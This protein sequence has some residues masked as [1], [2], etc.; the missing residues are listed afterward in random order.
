MGGVGR[1]QMMSESGPMNSGIP[2]VDVWISCARMHT[3]EPLEMQECI[4]NTQGLSTYGQK[5]GVYLPRDDAH[6]TS[7]FLCNFNLGSQ[8]AKQ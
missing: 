2:A 8:Y 5:I 4:G 1:I 7:V 3:P 6:P